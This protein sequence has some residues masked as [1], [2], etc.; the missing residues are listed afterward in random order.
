MPEYTREHPWRKPA[1]G[2]LLAAAEEHGID[3]GASWTVGDMA[4]DAAAGR[5]AGTRTVLIGDHAP[6]DAD[7]I[8]PD[9][10]AA[11]DAILREQGAVRR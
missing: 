9:I 8:A 10:G 3:L 5:A 1:P 2:M 4:R 7:V 6:E 11:T